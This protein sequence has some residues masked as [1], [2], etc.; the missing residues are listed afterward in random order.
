MMICKSQP[1]IGI[2]E[3]G[4]T[5]KF[6]VAPRSTFVTNRGMLH[7]LAKSSLL[8]VLEKLPAN[9]ECRTAIQDT[10]SRAER[11]SLSH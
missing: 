3:V 1:E 11:M 10:V 8:S 9:T 5:C 7:C 6:T 2:Q 4:E